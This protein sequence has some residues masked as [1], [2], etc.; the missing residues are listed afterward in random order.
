MVVTVVVGNL[1]RG[2]EVWG[3][4]AIT[5]K[6]VPL[7]DQ[8]KDICALSPCR[9]Q[10][11]CIEP[12]DTHCSSKITSSKLV[13]EPLL[14]PHELTYEDRL[15][16]VNE[17]FESLFESIDYSLLIIFLGMLALFHEIGSNIFFVHRRD[18]HRCGKLRFDRPSKKTL[19][20]LFTKFHRVFVYY[21]ILF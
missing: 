15:D 10:D 18:L 20:R 1:W 21:R 2:R 7:L 4:A 19:V 8:K 9:K 14:A 13:I 5:Y 6:Q 16:S 17:F 12:G 3:E 11:E